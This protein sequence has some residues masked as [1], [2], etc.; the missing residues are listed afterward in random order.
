MLAAGHMQGE[1]WGGAAPFVRPHE[2]VRIE[3][4]IDKQSEKGT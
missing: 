3:K 2:I 1:V 4:K